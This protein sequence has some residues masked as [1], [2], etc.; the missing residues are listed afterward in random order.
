MPGYVGEHDVP[1]VDGEHA[2]VG[3]LRREGI[4]RDLGPRVREMVEEGGLARIGEAHEAYVRYQLELDAQARRLGRLPGLEGPRGLVHRVLE[5][6]IAPAAL[7]A[8]EEEPRFAFLD[9]GRALVVHR[10]SP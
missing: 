2:E 6:G 9:L 7:A 10:R 8:L 5:M 3:N 4:G 1:L